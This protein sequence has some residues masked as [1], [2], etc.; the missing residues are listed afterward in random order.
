MFGGKSGVYRESM[1]EL[2]KDVTE[3][4][5]A[6][7]SE[8]GANAVLGVNIDYDSISAKGVSMFMVS[9]QGTAV[10]FTSPNEDTPIIADNEISW[11]ALNTEY[12][13]KK[14][15][16]K[17]NEGI[18]LNDDEWSF[19]Q[20]NKLFN[21]AKIL[22]VAKEG[23]LDTAISLLFVEKSSYNDVDLS[24]MKL[25]C[26][27]LNNLPEIASKEE[28]KGGLFSSGGLKFICSCGCKNDPKNEYC[29]ECGRNICGI[30]KKTEG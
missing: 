28:I 27:Y 21:A 29:T 24:E 14:I 5:K 1:N 12:H 8:I 4:L 16:C 22:E 7:A 11:E 18:A 26:D 6:K 23:K 20:K 17:L 19:A 3:G 25:L 15:I 9:I 30:T 13:K 2:C 10:K